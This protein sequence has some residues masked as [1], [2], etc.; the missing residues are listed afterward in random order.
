M[1]RA[2]AWFPEVIAPAAEKNEL[3]GIF[4]S[5]L[6]FSLLA[7]AINN[8]PAVLISSLAIEQ[9]NGPDYLPFASLLGTSVGA[10]WQLCYGCSSYGREALRSTGVNI[11]NTA[12]C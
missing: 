2:T 9:V 7:A 1:E 10:R 12:C 6:L 11:P 8:L 4:G 3:I 5:G